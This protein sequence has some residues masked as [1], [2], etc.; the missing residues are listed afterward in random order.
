MEIFFLSL[1]LLFL[2]WF[3]CFLR[4]FFSL[5]L[6]SFIGNRSFLFWVSTRVV[7]SFLSNPLFFF[8]TYPYYSLIDQKVVIYYY[9]ITLSN[10]GFLWVGVSFRRRWVSEKGHPVI[11]CHHPFFN[12]PLF[13]SILS[14]GQPHTPQKTFKYRERPPFPCPFCSPLFR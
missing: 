9:P 12:L 8:G 1:F 14:R 2:P 4:S 11:C 7:T 5:C 13:F 6:R 3:L 10:L